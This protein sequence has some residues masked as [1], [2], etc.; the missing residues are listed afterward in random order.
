MTQHHVSTPVATDRGPLS[1]VL[2]LRRREL[3]GL[4]HAP[5]LAEGDDHWTLYLPDTPLTASAN[6]MAEAATALVTHLRS[7]AARWEL[8]RHTGGDHTERQHLVEFIALCQDDQLCSW[9]LS[10]PAS[11][12]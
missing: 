7:Y 3:H 8:E 9:I 12:S 1:S 10:T 4:L 5:R 6:T 2:E 11:R